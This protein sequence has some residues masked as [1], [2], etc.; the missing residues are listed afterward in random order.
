MISI[1]CLIPPGLN[2][3]VGEASKETVVL[4]SRG[5]SLI[6]CD[7]KP[8]N[9]PQEEVIWEEWIITLEFRN[10]RSDNDRLNLHLALAKKLT[11]AVQTILTYT[12]SER[13]RAAVPLIST[14]QGLS[15][16]PY[17]IVL[18]VGGNEL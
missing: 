14:N 4:R 8:T 18:R 7:P 9:P 5:K 10:P 11:T 1:L 2:S 17:T 16:F 3:V 15:P 12:S 6:Y 13:G